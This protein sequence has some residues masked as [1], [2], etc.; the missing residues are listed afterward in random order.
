MV[1]EDDRLAPVPGPG[2]LGKH[3]THHEGLD[4]AA[5][6]CLEFQNVSLEIKR[7][8]W[9]LLQL[10]KFGIFLNPNVYNYLTWP[11]ATWQ[12]W[13]EDS[14]S[15][16]AS[17]RSRWSAGSPGRTGRWRR[18]RQSRIYKAASLTGPSGR[19]QSPRERGRS[20]SRSL[21]RGELTDNVWLIVPFCGETKFA[22]YFLFSVWSFYCSKLSNQTRPTTEKLTQQLPIQNITSE[23]YPGSVKAAGKE[24]DD[25]CPGAVEQSGVQVRDVAPPLLGDVLVGDV[26][27]TALTD[28]PLLGVHLP[29][30][31]WS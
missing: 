15:S 16:S 9:W 31:W 26:G 3:Q 24:Q 29:A 28:Y 27:Q 13:P 17:S 4:D 11:V 10:N 1:T 21:D 30:D 14:W 6:N 5:Q 20:G 23:K 8:L 2:Q 19:G 7:I 12:G 22:I 18:T 25:V